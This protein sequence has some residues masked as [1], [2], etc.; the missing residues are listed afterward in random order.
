VDRGGHIAY[1]RKKGKVSHE[2]NVHEGHDPEGERITVK[3]CHR[4]EKQD[5][6]SAPCGVRDDLSLSVCIPAFA[7][8]ETDTEKKF[9]AQR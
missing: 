2:K 4:Q 7:S 8:A 6:L 9:S 3:E 1:G 5:V